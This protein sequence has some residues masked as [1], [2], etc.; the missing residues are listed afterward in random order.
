MKENHEF[1]LKQLE[2]INNRVDVMV[3]Y[4]GKILNLM[5]LLFGVGFG[6]SFIGLEI[7]ELLIV[8]FPFA[9][10]SLIF[11]F[12]H[13]YR[14]IASYIAYRKFLEEYIS[15]NLLKEKILFFEEI[16]ENFNYKSRGLYFSYIGYSLMIGLGIIQSIKASLVSFNL[17]GVVAIIML[18]TVF[19]VLMLIALYEYKRSFSDA[20][21][22][23]K[24][25]HQKG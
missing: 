6:V 7:N 19:I 20:Y 5:L 4:D 18:H 3:A 2:A 15:K 17:T 11:Y 13:I 8:F 1:I 25:I 12:I 10:Y 22:A 23:S 21:I 14:I 16:T 24:E 9:I